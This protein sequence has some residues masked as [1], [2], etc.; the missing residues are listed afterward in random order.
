MPRLQH[1]ALSRAQAAVLCLAVHRQPGLAL[2]HTQ[3][4]AAAGAQALRA[5][6]KAGCSI[7]TK[8][9]CTRAEGQEAADRVHQKSFRAGAQCTFG[10]IIWVKRLHRPM[11]LGRRI[12]T[13]RA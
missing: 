3:C 4:P 8:S 1:E 6:N 9:G 13:M 10:G 2:H 7:T 5:T 11:T 12:D